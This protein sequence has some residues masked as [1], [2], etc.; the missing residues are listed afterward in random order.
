[1]I[2]G[3]AK[4]GHEDCIATGKSLAGSAQFQASIEM[5]GG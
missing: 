4:R 2:G 1:M 5:A 3:A